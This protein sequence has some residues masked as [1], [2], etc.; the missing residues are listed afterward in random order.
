MKRHEPET[1]F[2]LDL[3]PWAYDVETNLWV[4]PEGKI[5]CPGWL[6]KAKWHPPKWRNTSLHSTGYI[7][8]GGTFVHQVVA[9]AWIYRPTQNL[10][11]N[12]KNGNKR[13]NE[14]YN[15]EWVDY[16]K[17]LKHAYDHSLRPKARTPELVEA[18]RLGLSKNTRFW[19]ANAI[20]NDFG[21]GLTLI[22]TIAKEIKSGN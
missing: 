2:D 19:G 15:L 11:V 22:K 8:C 7:C 21:V 3:G 18:V 10:I 12:H 4:T 20:A 1:L 9:R 6:S 17:N 5:G 14:V 13:N 16:S